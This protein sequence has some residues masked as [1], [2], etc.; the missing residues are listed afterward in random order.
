MRTYRRQ[1]QLAEVIARELSDLM[2]SRM[3]DPRLGFA[4][5]TGVELS[6][7]LRHAKVFVSV[8]GDAEEQRA[9]MRAL[10]SANGFL[11]HELA[12]RLTVRHVPELEFKLD[13]SIERGAHV[14]NLINQVNASPEGAEG[15]EGSTQPGSN[16]SRSESRSDAPRD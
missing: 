15:A 8:M 13:S 16:E 7:D 9:S 6:P 1:D 10:A 5:I 2:R 14:L 11:R 12:Q 3:K 4:S